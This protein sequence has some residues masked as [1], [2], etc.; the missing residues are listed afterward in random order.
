M[1]DN[2]A[3]L[4]ASARKRRDSLSAAESA[5]K[6]RLIQERA[7]KFPLYLDAPAVALYS[8]TGNEVAT[9]AIRQHALNSGKKIFYPRLT[10]NTGLQ[11]VCLRE[12]N[13]FSA[14]R[15][16]ILE[17]TGD[18]YL[19]LDEADALVV[20]VPGL[21]FDVHGN[22]LGRGQGWYDRALATLDDRARTIALAYDWQIVDRVPS[23][24][25]DRSVQYIVTEE[26]II[27]CRDL[28]SASR[29]VAE[30]L[31]MKRGC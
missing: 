2:K 9:E 8:A 22:R 18:E 5:Q 26:R 13:Q 11:W 3:N 15:Y 19:S 7:L 24:A 12:E 30:S 17:P 23:D 16:G 28:A 21:A 14:G 25:W 29:P 4:R 10:T 20:F 31:S 27:D 6:S 1:G